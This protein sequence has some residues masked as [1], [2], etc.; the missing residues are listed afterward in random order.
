MKETLMFNIIR[1]ATRAAL[2]AT[3]ILLGVAYFEIRSLK[4]ELEFTNATL[5]R[6]NASLRH[7]N[8]LLRTQALKIREFNAN[9]SAREKAIIARYDLPLHAKR[10]SVEA[11][12][13][14]FV[15]LN[16]GSERNT[17]LE[18]SSEKLKDIEALLNVYENSK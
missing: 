16:Q 17:K 1:M 2:L 4:N 14:D 12:K 10:A 5:A 9:K 15:G 8:M 18:N 6:S 13:A 3:L 7:Q 11:G